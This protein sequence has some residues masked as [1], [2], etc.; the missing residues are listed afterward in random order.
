M[1]AWTEVGF[2]R[3]PGRRHQRALR[4]VL[5]RSGGN[6]EQ[7]AGGEG[8]DRIPW[9]L[10]QLLLGPGK[11][12]LAYAG[13]R[14]QGGQEASHPIWHGPAAP[15]HRDDSGLLAGGAR[16][17]GADVSYPSGSAA[18]GIGARRHHRH[19]Q[20]EPLPDGKLPA[21][22]QFR[23]HAAGDGRRQCF[24]HLD[25]RPSGGH[26]VRALRAPGRRRQLCQLRGRHAPDSCRPPSLPLRQGQGGRTA[27]DRRHVGHPSMARA[28]LPTT[29]PMASPRDP[30]YRWPRRSAAAAR[31]GEIGSGLPLHRFPRPAQS[32]QF[33]LFSSVTQWAKELLV[34]GLVD[35]ARPI[36]A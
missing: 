22:I 10:L 1:G 14:G 5:R 20:R 11:S 31:G 21:G 15:G 16:S 26:P 8:G 28:S 17:F 23:I 3:D 18:T 19:G 13:S 34:G 36:R 27:P 29:A 24:R 7:P 9:S 35:K 6:D 33:I 30:I 4:H 32:G 2:D 12:L 25:R